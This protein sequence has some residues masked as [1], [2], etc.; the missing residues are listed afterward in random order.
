M[1]RKNERGSHVEIGRSFPFLAH[2]IFS[3][4]HF[5][6]AFD[7]GF[8]SLFPYSWKNPESWGTWEILEDPE[9]GTIHTERPVNFL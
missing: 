9:V 5:D 3:A 1:C 8:L 6:E 7:D 2:R 4:F